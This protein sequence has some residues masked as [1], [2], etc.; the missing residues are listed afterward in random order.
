MGRFLALVGGS[1]RARLTEA[2]GHLR[3]ALKLDP[4]HANTRHD[5]AQTLLALGDT[6]AAVAEWERILSAETQHAM[7]CM[8]LGQVAFAREKYDEARA[9]FRRGLGVAPDTPYMLGN[10][11]MGYRALALTEWKLG[12]FDAAVDAFEDALAADPRFVDTYADWANILRER[13]REED[14]VAIFR[15]GLQK[16]QADPKFRLSF[17]NFLLQGKRFSEAKEQLLV[18]SRLSPRDPRPLAALGYVTLEAGNADEAISYLE[19]ALRLD[20]NS[21]LAHFHLGNALLRN[22][23]QAEAVSHYE[24]ALRLRPG[25]VPAREALDRLRSRGG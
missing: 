1:D 21:F 16:N 7:A 9:Y 20:P 12:R 8:G 19:G 5:C 25:F 3:A 24:A 4:T 11:G 15:R 23:R 2:L 18:A 13:G 22:G 14:G 6:T 10:R 17:G